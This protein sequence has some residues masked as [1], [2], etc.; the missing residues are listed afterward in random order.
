MAYL[1]TNLDLRAPLSTATYSYVDTEASSWGAYSENGNYCGEVVTT[2]EQPPNLEGLSKYREKTYEEI[3][4]KPKKIMWECPHTDECNV[5]RCVHH[6]PHEFE[7]D[8]CF[9]T[10]QLCGFGIVADSCV[11]VG[12]PKHKQVT[13]GKCKDLWED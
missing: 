10:R 8:D 9:N 11:R 5:S 7:E 6:G 1:K 12:G 4:N 2:L 13:E 3:F